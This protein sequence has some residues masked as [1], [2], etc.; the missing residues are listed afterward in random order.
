MGRNARGQRTRG[1]QRTEDKKPQRHK[2]TKDTKENIIIKKLDSDT[3]W[4]KAV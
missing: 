3:I 1:H 4:V 2:G